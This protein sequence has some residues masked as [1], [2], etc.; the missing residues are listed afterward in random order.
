[1]TIKEIEKLVSDMLATTKGKEIKEFII[2]INDV[3]SP[4]PCIT[5]PSVQIHISTK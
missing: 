3:P 5:L 1:M 2:K 4:N